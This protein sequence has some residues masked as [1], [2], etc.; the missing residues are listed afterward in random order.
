M[1]QVRLGL[2]QDGLLLS[3]SAEGHA[4]F[5]PKGRDI[6][7]AGLTTLLK[8]VL[9]QL[10]TKSGIDLQTVMGKRG[11]L[12]FRILNKDLTVYADFLTFAGTFL[13]QGIQNLAEEY[14]KHVSMRVIIE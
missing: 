14:P 4:G 5:A 13:Q 2:S 3:C 8:T 11:L 9:Q 1:V 12:A 6:V 7:C 10:E